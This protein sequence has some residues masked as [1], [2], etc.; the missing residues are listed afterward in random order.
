MYTSW[1]VLLEILRAP[2]PMS[3]SILINEHHAP[4][5]KLVQWESKYKSINMDKI[6]VFQC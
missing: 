3:T 6:L 5:K 1:A 4:K 2:F